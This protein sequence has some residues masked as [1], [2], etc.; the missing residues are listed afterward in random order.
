METLVAPFLAWCF[1]IKWSTMR[2]FL[3]NSNLHLDVFFIYV[4]EVFIRKIAVHNRYSL[5]LIFIYS[6]IDYID[7]I[8]IHWYFTIWVKTL[9]L[10]QK[11]SWD[12]QV[13]NSGCKV[14]LATLQKLST[15][16]KQLHVFMCVVESSRIAL[17]F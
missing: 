1:Q 16:S 13:S 15:T 6:Y 3:L 9:P 12:F 8:F 11:T 14:M 2:C 17:F 4:A 7:L 10:P 5:E